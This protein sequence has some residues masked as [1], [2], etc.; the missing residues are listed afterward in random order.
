MLDTD[1]C[2]CGSNKAYKDCHKQFDEHLNSI[3]L[4]AFK[5]QKRPPR[6]IIKNEKDIEGIRKSGII[7]N[8]ALDLIASKICAGM[9]TETINLLAHNYIVEHDGIPACLNYE[10]YPKSICVSINNVVCHG[11]PDDSR[12]LKEGDIVNIDVTVIKDGYHGDTS[13]MWIIGEGSIMAQRICKI[14]QDAL[15]AGMKAVRNGAH[16]GDI[17]AA[18]QAVAEPERFSVVREYCGHGISDVYHD[19]PQILHYGKKNTGLQ[20]TTGMTFTIEPMINQGVW[21][22]KTLP[23]KWTVITKDRKLSAQWEHT[24]MVTENG[25]EVFTKRP[26]ED[27]SF[28][29]S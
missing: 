13:K 4:K 7:N 12:I 9:D 6:N 19:E 14:A 17:G 29:N 22:T 8:G 11:I 3:K 16:V 27:L 5:G 23:D 1:L 18:I 15:Y 25:C 20:L 2:W 28:L 24:L 26:E 10:G 21:Q